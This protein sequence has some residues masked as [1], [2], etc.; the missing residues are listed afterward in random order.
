MAPKKNTNKKSQSDKEDDKKPAAK[1]SGSAKT[2]PTKDAQDYT[3]GLLD[4][5]VGGFNFPGELYSLR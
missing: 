4:D 3:Q 1:K 2:S 5:A